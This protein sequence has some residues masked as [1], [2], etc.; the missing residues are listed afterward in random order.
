MRTEKEIAEELERRRFAPPMKRAL[1]AVLAGR[2][3]RHAADAEGLD[4]RDVYKAAGTVEGLRQLHLRAWRDSWGE[5]FP[6]VWRH[7][8]ARLE[9]R[10][11][12]A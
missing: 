9:R 12:A 6:S 11:E 3:Y 5:G 2:S 1:L 4:H 10:D 7:H 8:L